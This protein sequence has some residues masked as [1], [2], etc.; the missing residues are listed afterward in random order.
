MISSLLRII[1]RHQTLFICVVTFVFIGG[2]FFGPMQA[3]PAR[4]MARIE[5]PASD[6]FG[7]W[8][9][10][11]GPDLQPL[12]PTRRYND[13]RVKWAAIASSG[14][15]HFRVSQRLGVE[16]T[17]FKLAASA[18]PGSCVLEIEGTGA[19][20]AMAMRVT[21][22]AVTELG[23]MSGGVRQNDASQVRFYLQRVVRTLEERLRTL[24]LSTS[25]ALL[26]SAD[27][28]ARG[29]HYS[30]AAEI[31]R[32]HRRLQDCSWKLW[33]LEVRPRPP[34]APLLRV[35]SWAQHKPTPSGPSVALY[36]MFLA[37]LMGT[38]AAVIRD[39]VVTASDTQQ[40]TERWP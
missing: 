27:H 16:A 15:F 38:V 23:R 19:T 8:T 21:D 40:A 1:D 17:K 7:E 32:T 2:H 3:P 28:Y 5:V 18:A 6:R 34:V 22:A 9:P 11:I 10:L 24:Q 12:T 31:E 29:L 35:I 30:R 39:R 14:E 20:P 33:M 36:W 13:P 25:P 26:D 4:A 37:M